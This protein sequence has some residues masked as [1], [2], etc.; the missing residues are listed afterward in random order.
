[1][2]TFI[3]EMTQ[4]G[5]KEWCQRQSQRYPD[6]DWT[7]RLTPFRS[8]IRRAF[9]FQWQALRESVGRFIYPWPIEDERG[10]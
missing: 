4:R 2:R 8:R 7:P 10:E 3:N 1:V 6:F 9:R 5:Y